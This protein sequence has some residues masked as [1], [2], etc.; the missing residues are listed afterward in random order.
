MPLVDFIK[1]SKVVIGKPEVM[2]VTPVIQK[3]MDK[4]GAILSKIEA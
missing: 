3:K 4:I 2:M 1:S